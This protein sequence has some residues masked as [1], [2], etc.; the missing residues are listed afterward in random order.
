M[1]TF[2]K[3]DIGTLIPLFDTTLLGLDLQD[4]VFPAIFVETKG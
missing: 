4:L 2:A 1:F 3:E